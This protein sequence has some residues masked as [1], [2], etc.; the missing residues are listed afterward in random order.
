MILGYLYETLGVD[1]KNLKTLKLGANFLL[2][3]PYWILQLWLNAMFEP[4]LQINKP[5]D[6]VEE[7]KHMQIKCAQLDLMTHTENGRTLQEA[8]TRYFMMFAKCHNFTPAMASFMKRI[9]GPEWF[10]Y[11]FPTP[12]VDQKEE[13]LEIWESFL[14]SKLFSTRLGPSK[15]NVKILRYQPN[16]VS[17]QFKINQIFPKP[18]F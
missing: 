17:Q 3:G 14:I 12:N 10:V 9:H 5:N 18:F 15:D 11:E 6:D 1:V 8:F 2:V 13:S 16:L 7:I 4:S